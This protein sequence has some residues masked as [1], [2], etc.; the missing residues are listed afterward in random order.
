MKCNLC[1]KEIENYHPSFNSFSI[2]ENHTAY[3]CSQCVEKFTK[4]QQRIYTDLFPT[5]AVKKRFK[6]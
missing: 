3:I 6:K 1:E 4:W 2:D 5:K